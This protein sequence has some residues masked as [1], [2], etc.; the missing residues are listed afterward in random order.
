MYKMIRQQVI[1]YIRFVSWR[2]YCSLRRKFIPYGSDCH[3]IIMQGFFLFSW[4]RP[5]ITKMASHL[6]LYLWD[7]VNYF[8]LQPQNDFFGC[9]KK[10]I[11][12]KLIRCL[13]QN[14]SNVKLK[15]VM[16]TV[17]S[18]F[19]S[20]QNKI[21]WAA[22]IWCWL[23]THIDSRLIAFNVF[24]H[25]WKVAERNSTHAKQ[26]TPD[27]ILRKIDNTYRNSILDTHRARAGVITQN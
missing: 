11:Q 15:I 18:S 27:Y 25:S 10:R 8:F 6:F 2:I 22:I 20:F 23:L 7:Y 12:G 1:V 26:S 13:R 17:E 14:N 3:R 4:L 16:N 21:S 24:L 5:S 19:F 9:S